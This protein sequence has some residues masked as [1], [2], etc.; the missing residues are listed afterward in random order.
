[1]LNTM[2]TMSRFFF[3]SSGAILTGTQLIVLFTGL[4]VS[5]A[6]DAIPIGAVHADFSA[7]QLHIVTLRGAIIDVQEVP[8]YIGRLGT[9][10]GACRFFL[11]DKTG[12]IE[13]QVGQHCMP[14]ELATAAA[15]GQTYEVRGMVQIQCASKCP[16]VSVVAVEVKPVGD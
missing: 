5:L 3:G 7:H 1:M 4:S 14:S 6:D 13:I 15:R 12:M 10:R 11:K 8:P 9:I 16:V 2:S